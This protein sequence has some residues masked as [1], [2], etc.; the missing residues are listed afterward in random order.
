MALKKSSRKN[1]LLFDIARLWGSPEG[2]TEKHQINVKPVLEDIDFELASALKGELLFIKMKDMIS[3]LARDMSVE[4]KFNCV[5]CLK[6][7]SQDVDFT[8]IEREFHI[9]KQRDDQ[10][11]DIYYIDSKEMTI[12]LADMFRQEIILH[13]PLIPVCSKRCKGLCPQCGKDRNRAACKCR[14]ETPETHQPF[15][16]LKK[17]IK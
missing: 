16:N 9:K 17:L 12:D 3:V 11:K 14:Q 1:P 7:F 5:K 6:S 2:T 15:K 10:L 13:F 8:D 4:V